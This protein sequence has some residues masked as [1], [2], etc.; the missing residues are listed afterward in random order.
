[1]ASKRVKALR[2]VVVQRSVT[3]LRRSVIIIGKQSICLCFMG[4]GLTRWLCLSSLTS[5]LSFSRP[6]CS[7]SLS[8]QLC[9]TC[10]LPIRERFVSW[11]PFVVK[12]SFMP[13]LP[14]SLYYFC[15]CYPALN[16]FCLAC[17]YGYVSACFLWFRIL[18]HYH[19]C[20]V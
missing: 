15:T 5:G 14:S 11:Q 16:C 3:L 8:N 7:A 12:T 13:F 20:L 1:M 17:Q 10:I 9:Q 4:T 2:S 6:T 19:H 18:Y